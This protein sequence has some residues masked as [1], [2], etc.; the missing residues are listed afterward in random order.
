M[1]RFRTVAKAA[2]VRAAG[3]PTVSVLLEKLALKSQLAYKKVKKL[4][5]KFYK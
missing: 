5:D 1:S 3:Y 4:S 2:E